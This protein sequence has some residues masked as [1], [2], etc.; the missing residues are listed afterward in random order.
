MAVPED[1]F[2][3]MS[4]NTRQRILIL[5]DE[6]PRCVRDIVDNFRISQPSISRHLSVLKSVGLVNDE[7]S[8]QKVVYSLNHEWL[9]S[10]CEDSFNRFNCCKSLFKSRIFKEVT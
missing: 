5:L 9:R 6:K 10:C 3:A 2:H 4:D 1:F 7:R 8:G